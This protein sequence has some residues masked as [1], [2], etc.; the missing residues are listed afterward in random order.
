MTAKR[1]ELWGVAEIAAALEV[2]PRTVYWWA[3]DKA[4]FPPPAA[5]LA[6]GRVWLADDVRKWRRHEIARRRR[7]RAF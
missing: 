1:T 6:S 2:A 7:Q 3:R 4:S 5:E